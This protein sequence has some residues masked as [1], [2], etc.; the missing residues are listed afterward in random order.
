[1]PA[2]GWLIW[3]EQLS[4][5]LANCSAETSRILNSQNLKKEKAGNDFRLFVW[6][7][8]PQISEGF[9]PAVY[10]VSRP[11]WTPGDNVVHFLADRAALGFG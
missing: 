9:N 11:Y 2:N 4:E 8:C 6:G 7:I 5:M 10:S 1:M 3:E